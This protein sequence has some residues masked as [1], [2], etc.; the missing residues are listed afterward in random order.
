MP[1]CPSTQEN[2]N[3]VTSV[4][5]EAVCG[6]EQMHEEGGYAHGN[7][8]DS[9]SDESISDEYGGEIGVFTQAA[10]AD[11]LDI[12]DDKNSNDSGDSSNDDAVKT[13]TRAIIMKIN[14]TPMDLKTFFQMIVMMN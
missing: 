11:D 8:D 14:L 4:I 13:Q 12:R 2:F 7:I 9:E 6:P 10:N 3:G 5:L 1:T